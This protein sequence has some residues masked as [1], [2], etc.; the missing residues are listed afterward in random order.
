MLKHVD[1]KQLKEKCDIGDKNELQYIT[2]A[3]T[4]MKKKHGGVCDV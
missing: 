1:M 2:A 4:R 3:R